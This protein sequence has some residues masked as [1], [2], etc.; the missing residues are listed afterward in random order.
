MREPANPDALQIRVLTIRLG[1]VAAIYLGLR[2]LI[3][4]PDKETDA[5]HECRGYRHGQ[6]APTHPS[7]LHTHSR[8]ELNLP[9]T[10]SP[11]ILLCH[12]AICS[13][14]QIFKDLSHL[15]S[16]GAASR[17]QNAP[18]CSGVEV[19]MAADRVRCHVRL[20]PHRFFV[21]QSSGF[22]CAIEVVPSRLILETFHV[23]QRAAR[24]LY[25]VKI[26]GNLTN[27][28]NSTC[29]HVSS[30]KTTDPAQSAR[31]FV[32]HQT[33]IYDLPAFP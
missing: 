31:V 7:S 6:P 19:R 9:C 32:A 11:C 23:L 5:G 15:L 14:P 13:K 16:S 10:A 8:L 22:D 27:I 1:L 24:E 30:I 3:S 12:Q 26:H 2:Y 29:V 28:F 25:V 4:P 18:R 17:F 33:S 20:T 21:R